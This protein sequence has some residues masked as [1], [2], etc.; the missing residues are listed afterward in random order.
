MTPARQVD[1]RRKQPLHRRGPSCSSARS[2]LAPPS[3]LRR[4]SDDREGGLEPRNTR[5]RSDNLT[6][7]AW[8]VANLAAMMALKPQHANRRGVQMLIGVVNA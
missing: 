8:I 6:R 3:S 5:A 1:A 2:P 7:V 4:V